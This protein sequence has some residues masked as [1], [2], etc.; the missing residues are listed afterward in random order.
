MKELFKYYEGD[1]NV[2]IAE[3]LITK[4]LLI[5]RI[6]SLVSDTLIS[7]LK[8]KGVVIDNTFKHTLD[9]N[10]IR[11][12][13]KVHGSSNELL[14]GQIP[15]TDSDLLLIPEIVSSYDKITVDKNSRKQDVIIYTKTMKD[16]ISFFVE[17][18][19]KGRHELAASS[20]YKRKKGDSPTLID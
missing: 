8:E 1:L 5:K 6:I 10:A 4:D 15:I 9:N 14:R 3:S 11:H 7:D 17:E 13:I 18:I 16:G 12:V 20:M 2:F 19:R